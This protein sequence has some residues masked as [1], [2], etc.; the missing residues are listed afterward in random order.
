MRV[1]GCVPPPHDLLHVP[2]A[3]HADTAHGGAKQCPL[4]Q[5]NV[6]ASTPHGVPSFA[7][8]VVTDRERERCPAPQLLLHGAQLPHALATHAM[9]HVPVLHASAS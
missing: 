4:L 9:L 1:R 3:P 2:H 6:W 5:S 7:A 8:G